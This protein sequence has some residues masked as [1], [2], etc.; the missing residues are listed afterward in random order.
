MEIFPLEMFDEKHRPIAKGVYNQIRHGGS[1]D[2]P[3]L[4]VELREEGYCRV[5][6]AAQDGAP[7]KDYERWW[8]DVRQKHRLDALEERLRKLKEDMEG[9]DDSE[10]RRLF[11]EY[12]SCLKERERIRG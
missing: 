9:A 5:L 10:S 1:V 7:G 12:A 8:T 3:A 6:V 2:V 11:E 4:L